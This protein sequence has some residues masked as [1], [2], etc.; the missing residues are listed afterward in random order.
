MEF[1][2]FGCRG[3]SEEMKW[4]NARSSAAIEDV[5]SCSLPEPQRLRYDA[6]M[7]KNWS[8]LTY[9]C[10]ASLSLLASRRIGWLLCG[11]VLP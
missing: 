1:V 3:P 10:L 9:D 5:S 6:S 11:L 4:R 8:R 7:V 2:V